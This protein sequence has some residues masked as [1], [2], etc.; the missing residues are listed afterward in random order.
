MVKTSQGIW[1]VQSKW[2]RIKIDQRPIQPL[3]SNSKKEF[4]QGD[5]EEPKI[6]KETRKW[7]KL[8]RFFQEKV[9]INGKPKEQKE[10]NSKRS[11]LTTMVVHFDDALPTHT[12]MMRSVY[13]VVFA[14]LACLDSGLAVVSSCFWVVASH[15]RVSWAGSRPQCYEFFTLW[16]GNLFKTPRW[17]LL[18]LSPLNRN[19]M[20][21]EMLKKGKE[22]IQLAQLCAQESRKWP[23]CSWKWLKNSSKSRQQSSSFSL[24]MRETSLW[25]LQ[26]IGH[27]IVEALLSGLWR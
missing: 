9:W 14:F 12:A 13:F 18:R 15:R 3:F 17:P 1:T 23:S 8:K 2:L 19:K 5:H 24:Q 25:N 22:F 16:M 4:T 7:N 10:V 21:V 6:A 11:L 27:T 20:E 26:G